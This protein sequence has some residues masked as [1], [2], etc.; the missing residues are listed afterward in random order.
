MP[1]FTVRISV[2][3]L[4]TWSVEPK[5]IKQILRNMGWISKISNDISTS[6]RKARPPLKELPAILSYCEAS[7]RPGLSA[8][9]LA[10]AIISRLPEMGIDTGVNPD[11][12]KNKIL[13]F[14]RILSEE[15]VKEIKNNA[16]ATISTH[17]G[18]VS[19]TGMAGNIPVKGL[20]DMFQ[21]VI[22]R[23]D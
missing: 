2:K 11:G 15:I 4:K 23:V 12:S 14:I 19:F 17:P 10:S 3:N 9:S 13:Q 22:G 21:N 18:N 5:V 1:I 8:I 16:K 20:N 7:E 6:L